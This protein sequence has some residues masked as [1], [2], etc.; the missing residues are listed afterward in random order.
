LSPASS[1]R[2]SPAVTGEA[3]QRWR[4]TAS[5][6]GGGIRMGVAMVSRCPAMAMAEFPP[7]RNTQQ[8]EMPHLL[9]EVTPNITPHVRDYTMY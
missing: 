9:S 1:E 8:G 6:A 3:A 5:V 2:E 4:T 7:G